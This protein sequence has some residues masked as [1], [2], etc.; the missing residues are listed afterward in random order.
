MSNA[1]GQDL[2]KSGCKP[3]ESRAKI[4]SLRTESSVNIWARHGSERHDMFAP[5]AKLIDWCAIQATSRRVPDTD[6]RSLRLEQAVQ[7]LKGPDFIATESKPAQME[8]NP[9]NSGLHFRF[10]TPRPGDFAENNIVYGRLYH[11]SERWQERPVIVLLHGW[12]SVLSH[13]LRFPWIARR[14]NRAGFNAATMELPYHFQRRPRQP[15]ALGGYDCL[16]LAERTGQA[17]AE[18]RALTGWLL[19]QG[20]P[21]VAL[22]GG[23]YGGWLAGL[24]VC[25]DAR[26]NAAVLAVPGVRSNRSRADLVLWPKVREAMRQRE[27]A[28]ETLDQTALNLTTKQPAIPREN[29]LLI[30]AAHDLLTPPAPIEELWRHWRQPD[31]WR[32]PHGH[33]SF[34]LIG[35]PGLMAA[36]VLGWLALRLEKAVRHGHLNRTLVMRQ[37]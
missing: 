15:G 30:E 29:I 13:R 16:G 21:A 20:C 34:S 17:I 7:F 19:E 9:N 31:I 28:L 24:T 22:W 14:C 4:I 2:P 6:I 37:V 11:C 26:V 1:D 3:S 25:Y 33:F 32:V 8:F 18:I 10:P 12:N 5:L 23:S 27:V 35:A 36:R